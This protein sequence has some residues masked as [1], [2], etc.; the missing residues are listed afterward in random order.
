MVKGPFPLG[1]HN[2]RV[3]HGYWNDPGVTVA[4]F[5]FLLSFLLS[6]IQYTLNL[7]RDAR[8][9]RPVDGQLRRKQQM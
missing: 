9:S 5:L 3:G 7:L 6:F 4:G 1:Y 8:G 2:P